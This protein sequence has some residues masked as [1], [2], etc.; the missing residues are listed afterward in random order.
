MERHRVFATS[1]ALLLVGCAT[2]PTGG[3]GLEGGVLA[4]FEVSGEQFRAWVTNETAIEQL[5]GLWDGL[6]EANIPNGALIAGPGPGDHNSPW[7]W[8]LDAEDIE[9]AE[10]TIEVCD[11]RPSLVDD[12]LEDYLAVG[13]FCPWG[14]ELVGI[15]DRR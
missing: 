9:M 8:H 7:K 10:L 2:N 13:R 12:L 11:G 4:T 1:L 14:A 15:E 6:S 5:V 3:E